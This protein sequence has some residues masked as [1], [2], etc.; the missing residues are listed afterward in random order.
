MASPKIQ[1]DFSKIAASL[2]GKLDLTQMAIQSLPV[3]L[4]RMVAGNPM[5]QQLLAQ[6]GMT[7]ESFASMLTQG[8]IEQAAAPSKPSID[9]PTGGARQLMRNWQAV[10]NDDLRLGLEYIWDNPELDEHAESLGN[11]LWHAMGAAHAAKM[12]AARLATSAAAKG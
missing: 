5:G 10:S 4:P 3:I 12:D 2:L 11:L 7:P 9:I 1:I 6:I 8:A